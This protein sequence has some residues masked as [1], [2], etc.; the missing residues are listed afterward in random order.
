MIIYV[1]IAKPT[2]FV[3]EEQCLYFCQNPDFTALIKCFI[4]MGEIQTEGVNYF[5]VRYFLTVVSKRSS[6]WTYIRFVP[7]ARG[8]KVSPSRAMKTY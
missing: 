7:K 3:M 8:G 2:A 5:T 4:V 6:Q 1:H